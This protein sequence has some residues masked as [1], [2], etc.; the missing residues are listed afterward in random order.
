MVL[1][2]ILCRGNKYFYPVNSRNS[3]METF[4]ALVEKDLIKLS[5]GATT[6]PTGSRDNLTLSEKTA[7]DSLRSWTNLVIQKAD[8]GGLVMVLNMS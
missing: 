6:E 2:K 8:K 1:R 5:D 7:I 4:Q 3:A